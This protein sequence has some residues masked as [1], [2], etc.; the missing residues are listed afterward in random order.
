MTTPLRLPDAFSRGRTRA[1]AATPTCCCCCCCCAVS[2]AA[3]SVALP[4]GFL[5]DTAGT[6]GALPERDRSTRRFAAALLALLPAA[7]ILT[8]FAL[9]KESLAGGLVL[10]VSVFG[11]LI[12][13]GAI[14]GIGGSAARVNGIMRYLC[15]VLAVMVEFFLGLPILG[16]LAPLPG[17][18]A[19]TLY[20]GVAVAVAIFLARSYARRLRR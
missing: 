11:G 17:P 20:L 7:V 2:T 16:M 6:A 12:A 19:L 9:T 3:A 15:G 8:A 13:V 18:L 10:V 1:A 4:M 14:G 5:A